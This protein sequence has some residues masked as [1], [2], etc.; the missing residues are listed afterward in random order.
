MRRRFQSYLLLYTYKPIQN[1]VPLGQY[2]LKYD[3]RNF[4][5]RNLNLLVLRLLHTKYQCIRGQWFVREI[6]KISPIM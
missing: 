3:P 2:H 5:C 1:Y 4:I 6:P